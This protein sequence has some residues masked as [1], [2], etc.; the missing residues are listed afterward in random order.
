M[1]KPPLPQDDE[2]HDIPEFSYPAR[3]RRASQ[4]GTAQGRRVPGEYR[5]DERPG[6]PKIKRASLLRERQEQQARLAAEAR[7]E[8]RTGKA[9]A[10][11]RPSPH[12]PDTTRARAETGKAIRESNRPS[13]R[14]R[15]EETSSARVQREP[16][17]SHARRVRE[18]I[19]TIVVTPGRRSTGAYTPR[20]SATH[21]LQR[22]RSGSTSYTRSRPRPLFTRKQAITTVCLLVVMIVLF[23]PIALINKH[24]SSVIYEINHAWPVQHATRRE[25]AIAKS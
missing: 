12:I 15:P 8:E 20:Q 16:D 10:V 21:P 11:K 5:T 3:Q 18:E 24:N 13:R 22:G 17:V 25:R 9:K 7:Q 1:Y 4:Y 2:P 14:L 6:E 19:D 23:I